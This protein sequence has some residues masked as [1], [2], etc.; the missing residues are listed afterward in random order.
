MRVLKYVQA[1]HQNTKIDEFKK[2]NVK[3]HDN[4]DIAI[5]MYLRRFEVNRIGK[6]WSG[7]VREDLDTDV[8]LKSYLARKIYINEKRI[9]IDHYREMEEKFTAGL[10]KIWSIEQFGH[11]V[12]ELNV[13]TTFEE[14]YNILVNK[15]IHDKFSLKD[16][17]DLAL[18]HSMLHGYNGFFETFDEF[19]LLCALPGEKSWTLSQTFSQKSDNR[20]LSPQR[21]IQVAIAMYKLDYLNC[22][23]P[24][25]H[26]W[27]Q[28]AMECMNYALCNMEK[29][30]E[31]KFRNATVYDN[32]EICE[33]PD[34]YPPPKPIAE[35]I[36]KRT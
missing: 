28:K 10:W 32:P 23:E 13:P 22:S 18:T 25:P 7:E 36:K 26:F 29:S 1:L 9:Y 8:I 19:D 31:I 33:N 35:Y 4:K 27:K 24:Y 3:K 17:I 6:N 21:C 34:R 11:E 15:N 5:R 12:P 2:E 16:T 30:Y 14:L 20:K